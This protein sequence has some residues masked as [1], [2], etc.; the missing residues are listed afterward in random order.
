[1]KCDFSLTPLLLFM[2]PPPPSASL[3]LLLLLVHIL[4]SPTHLP[5]EFSIYVVLFI[6]KTAG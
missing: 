6:H 2:S 3:L 1:M 4:L 5:I